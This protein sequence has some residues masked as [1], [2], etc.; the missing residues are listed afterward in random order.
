MKYP[1]FD[2]LTNLSEN[3]TAV[4]SSIKIGKSIVNFILLSFVIGTI[5][6]SCCPVPWSEILK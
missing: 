6:T 2:K 4:L 5:L 1:S 3:S